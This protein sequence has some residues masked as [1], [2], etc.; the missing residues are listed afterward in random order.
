MICNDAGYLTEKPALTFVRIFAITGVEIFHFGERYVV[1]TLPAI[2]HYPP[3]A[4]I[5]EH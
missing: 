1:L 3:L 5:G 2:P 4:L